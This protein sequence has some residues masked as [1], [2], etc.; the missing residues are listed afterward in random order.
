M[1]K[2]ILREI[3]K[4]LHCANPWLISESKDDARDF[5]QEKTHQI[6]TDHTR[7]VQ[8]DNILA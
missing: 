5:Y 1:T 4:H 6:I 2:L 7:Y 3:L 8:V